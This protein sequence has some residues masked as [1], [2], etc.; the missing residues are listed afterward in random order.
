[1]N[2]IGDNIILRA[3]EPTD[4][5]ILYK[6]EN[7]QNIWHLSNTLTPFSRY[8]LQKYIENSQHDIFTTRQLRLII[9]LKKTHRTIG[10]IDLFDF[11]P[12]HKRAGI[13]IL[14]GEEIEQG[15]GFAKESLKTL[16]TYCKSTLHLHQVYCNILVNNEVSIN[17]F[18]K[19]GF[20]LVGS[21]KQWIKVGDE[22]I[23][24]LLFQY[25]F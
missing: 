4:I 13:G 21:K 19:I 15:K 9:S 7:N 25:L 6:W 14:I 18:K 11:D 24:E 1:M 8:I 10:A 17:L 20:Q 23:D 3:L 2:I 5:D 22:F 16:L 12:F